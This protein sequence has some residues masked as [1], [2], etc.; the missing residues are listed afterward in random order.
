MP[1]SVAVGALLLALASGACKKSK[2]ESPPAA[3]PPAPAAQKGLREVLV[4]SWTARDI[5]KGRRQFTA[6]YA[7]DGVTE[8]RAADGRSEKENYR[9][10]DDRTIEY[11]GPPAVK[12]TVDRVTDDEL[13][14]T[15]PDG[16]V[17]E[18]KRQR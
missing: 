2:P 10:V 16:V 4:G 14:V 13:K 17:I 15:F 3:T 18:L 8:T 7:A 9:V 11:A 5:G 1:R 6:T 12:G